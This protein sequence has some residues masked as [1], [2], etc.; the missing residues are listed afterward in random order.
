MLGVPLAPAREA[1]GMSRRWRW[2]GAGAGGEEA[3]QACRHLMRTLGFT[4]SLELGGHGFHFTFWHLLCKLTHWRSG[5]SGNCKKKS[6][7]RVN[8]LKRKLRTLLFLPHQ[9]LL[10][11]NAPVCRRFLSLTFTPGLKRSPRFTPEEACSRLSV[12]ICCQRHAHL[13]HGRGERWKR[14]PF[15]CCDCPGKTSLGAGVNLLG[16]PVHTSSPIVNNI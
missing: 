2:P 15:I 7:K 1:G 10:S 13:Q 6:S 14:L 3:V 8:V 11:P 9:R 12:C 16:S 4:A 5:R